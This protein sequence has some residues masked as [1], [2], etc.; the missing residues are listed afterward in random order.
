MKTAGFNFKK[1]FGERTGN[2]LGELKIETGISI[3][4]IKPFNSP[5]KSKE[6][7][8]EIDFDYIVNYNPEFAKIEL[9]GTLIVA[10]EPKIAKE[11]LKE[12]KEKKIPEKFKINLF[13]NI[14]KKATIKAIQVED[15]LHLPPH[16]N[17]PTI[18]GK[19]GEQDKN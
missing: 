1:I 3:S 4:E 5:L 14:L 15:E 8:L 18:A 11:V 16:I 13:N 19:Q 17:L 10:L 2:S 9:A 7:P 6:E 12:W